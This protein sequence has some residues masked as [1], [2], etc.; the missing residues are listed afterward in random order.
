MQIASVKSMKT[1]IRAGD[2]L[3]PA[4]AELER[5]LLKALG[6]AATPVAPKV[7]IASVREASGSSEAQ[8]RAAAEDLLDR[9]CI[10]VTEDWKL[11]VHPHAHHVLV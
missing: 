7:L 10:V 5:S 8:I 9:G 1:G 6:E 2:A 3:T 11:V 4:I